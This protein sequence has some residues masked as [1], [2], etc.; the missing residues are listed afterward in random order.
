MRKTLTVAWREFRHTAMTKAFFFGAIIMPILMMGLFIFAIPLL[1]SEDTPL[2]GTVIVIAPED[3]VLELQAQISVVSSPLDEI[4]QQLPDVIAH[5]SLAGALL[6]KKPT[7]NIQI[8]PAPQQDLDALK[9]LVRDGEYV[10]LIV[11]PEA[12][13][14]ADKSEEQLE[15]FIPNSF[16][17]NHTDILTSATSRSVVDVRLRRLGH[18][19]EH[20]HDLIRRPR[21]VATVTLP[22]VATIGLKFLAVFRYMRFPASSAFHALTRDTSAVMP[23]SKM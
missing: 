1:E 22:D 11:V 5:D 21:T 16:S 14:Q 2:Q 10:G 20:I 6:P 9:N 4:I 15:V 19:P 18:N 3:V 17:P 7:T 23:R 13:V 12:V 8:I